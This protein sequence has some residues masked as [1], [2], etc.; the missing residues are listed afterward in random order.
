[1]G[2]GRGWRGAL[3][4]ALGVVGAS[5][6]GGEA[7]GLP[8]LGPAPNF[9]L[10]TQLNDRL[11]LTH[12]RGRIVVLSFFC[13]TCEACPHLLPS[14]VELSRSLDEA[15]RARVFFVAVSVDPARDTWPV[16]RRFARERGADPRSWA[17]LTAE[18]RAQIDVVARWYGAEVERAAGRVRHACRVTLIDGAGH[19]R[20]RP[21]APTAESL[22]QDLRTLLAELPGS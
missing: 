22:R 14:L 13:T 16:L 17:F 8:R 7:P 12:L 19:V 2:R 20:A 11:W 1:V 18:R 21:D 9:A 10:T 4:V 6:A 15:A 3:A 5:T